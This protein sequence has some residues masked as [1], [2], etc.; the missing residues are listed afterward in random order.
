MISFPPIHSSSDLVTRVQ[1]V[2]RKTF[3]LCQSAQ[4]VA[5][6]IAAIFKNAN[7]GAQT[8]TFGTDAPDS[9]Q[10]LTPTRYVVITESDGKQTTLLGW[11]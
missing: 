1:D 6:A 3:A 10:T 9:I 2:I 7:A 11:R 8:L 4:D 5:I